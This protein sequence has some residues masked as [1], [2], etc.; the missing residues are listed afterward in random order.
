M[1]G[2]TTDFDRRNAGY[3]PDR[4][5]ALVWGLSDLLVEPMPNEG[6]FEYYRREAAALALRN[7]SDNPTG[8]PEMTYA[9]GSLEYAAQQ[10]AK[11]M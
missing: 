5:D 3:S 10:L 11:G 1:C 7:K 9:P 6:I 4:V 8:R 2:F